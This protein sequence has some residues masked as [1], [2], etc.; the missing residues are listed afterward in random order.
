MTVCILPTFATGLSSSCPHTPLY[1][2]SVTV[3]L[4]RERGKGTNSGVTVY[5]AV[6]QCS[7][8][9]TLES[10]LTFPTS[11]KI[12]VST[13]SVVCFNMILNLESD[14]SPSLRRPFRHVFENYWVS[15]DFFALRLK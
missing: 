3:Y 10:I 5:E 14:T 2:F 4:L 1:I 15:M 11:L 9:S 8:P 13:V 6:V 7:H 12:L